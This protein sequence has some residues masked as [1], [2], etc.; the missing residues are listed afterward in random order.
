MGPGVF[1]LF[2]AGLASIFAKGLSDKL[3]LPRSSIM[4]LGILVFLTTFVDHYS[5][6]YILTYIPGLNAIR[7]V[8]RISVVE[9]FFVA[10]VAAEGLRILANST[11]RAPGVAITA[12]FLTLSVLDILMIRKPQF[13]AEEA[14][15]RTVTIVEEARRSSNGKANPV[16]ALMEEGEAPYNVHLDAMFAA[17]RLGWPTSNGY[18]GNSPPGYEYKPA[19]DTPTKQFDAYEKWH[20]ANGIGPDL[21][22]ADLL[23]R[24]IR[25]G[26]PACA[27]DGNLQLSFGPPPNDEVA[28]DLQL[29]PV[30][31]ELHGDN[32]AVELDI[33]NGG[34]RR[35]SA[36]SFYPIR[37]S[38]RFVPTGYDDP[39]GDKI[40]WDQH[41]LPITGDLLPKTDLRMKIASDIPK[42]PGTYQLEVSMVAERLFWFHDKGMRI[43]RFQQPIVVR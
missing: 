23:N 24:I 33:H 15:F 10:I 39:S 26:S 5:P 34:D 32:L 6:Y 27:T 16:L 1:G 17:Q 4:T 9:M 35:V 19:C 31:F 21:Y 42:K 36:V 14:E 29:S 3:S 20:H 38:W 13:S 28:R 11:P 30:S 2:I 18:S 41:R 25:F 22:T 40:S 37:L 8:T 7:S 43:L 12:L